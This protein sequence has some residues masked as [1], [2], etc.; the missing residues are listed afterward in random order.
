MQTRHTAALRAQ[1]SLVAD[2]VLSA[3]RRM[4]AVYDV[5]F[6]GISRAARVRAVAHVNALP[7]CR[8]LEAGVGTGLSL[9]LY[10][11]DKRITG[12]DL[13]A[14]MLARARRKVVEQGLSHVE[15]L[16]ELDAERT[17]LPDASFDIAVGM[18]V[19]SVVPDPPRLLAEMRRITRP[20]GSLVF[21]NH[22]SARSGP[23]LWIERLLAPA[24]RRIGWRPDFPIAALLPPDD[25]ARADRVDLPPLG[26]FSLVALRN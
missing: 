10:A 22:F 14:E 13:S 1:R 4:S 23:R 16:L 12:I 9:P 8:V 15:D 20:G 21:L 7:G 19:A 17:G 25:I 5:A 3:Y 11:R 6:G 26:L 24:A 18:F 2:D